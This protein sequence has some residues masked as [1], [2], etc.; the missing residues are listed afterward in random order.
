MSG[1]VRGASCAWSGDVGGGVCGEA[2][3]GVGDEARRC[4]CLLGTASSDSGAERD[5][6]ALGLGGL[7]QRWG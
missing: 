3:Y 5:P 2:E 7:E 4:S 6:E 1:G